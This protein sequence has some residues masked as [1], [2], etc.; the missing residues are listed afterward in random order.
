MMEWGE[1][2]IVE[3]RGYWRKTNAGIERVVRELP[4]E[5]GDPPFLP[6]ASEFYYSTIPPFQCLLF[7]VP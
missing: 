7:D 1:Q 5:E 4:M 6:K 3:W 2:G